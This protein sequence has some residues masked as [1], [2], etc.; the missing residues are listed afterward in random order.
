M[1]RNPD[2]WEGWYW[3]GEHIWGFD[4]A[5]GVMDQ[6]D[7]LEDTMQNTKLLIHWSE[8]SLTENFMHG[9]DNVQWTHWL[10]ELG[11]ERIFVTPDLNQAAGKYADKWI[12]VRPGTDPALAAAIANVWITEG[13]YQKDY[14]N[15]HGYGFDKWNAYVMGAEDGVPKTPEWAESITGVKA[16]EIR[17]L[18]RKWASTTTSLCILFGGACRGPYSTEW[19]RMMVLLLTMQGLGKPGVSYYQTVWS[20]PRDPTFVPIIGSFAAYADTNPPNPVMQSLYQT[21]LPGGIL[22]PPVT[23]Y[24]SGFGSS[25]NEQFV[26][27]TYP[28]K[29]YSEAKMI[30]MDNVARIT[31]WNCGNK[32]IEAYKSPKIQFTVAVH[33]WLENDMLFA[34]LILPESTWLEQDDIATI[35]SWSLGKGS[36]FGNVASVYM[37]KCIQ[38]L[39]ES[40]NP[41]DIYVAIASRLGIEKQYTEG[42]TVEDWIKTIFNKSTLPKFITY[43]DFKEKGY[44]VYKFPDNWPRN[45]GLQWFYNKPNIATPSDGVVTPSGKVEFYSQVLAKNFPDDKERPP[46]PHYIAEGPTHQESLTSAHAKTY[47]LL[48]E[49]AH[50][51]YRFHSR[52]NNISWLNEIPAY[53]VWNK[54]VCYEAV[55]INPKDASARGIKEGDVVRVFNERGGTL[56]A[57]HVTERVMPTVI[58]FSYGGTYRPAEPGKNYQDTAG[59]SNLISPYE[60]IS[61]NVSGMA[62]NG[63]LA[64]VEKWVGS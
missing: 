50:P 1:V 29:G 7:V 21:V 47:P 31:N 11:V 10:K 45:P 17:A 53:K 48:V 2:S 19:P 36:K 32:W 41:Y 25:H 22:N 39:G 23:W 38:P 43:D 58:R 54:G 60:T 9:C 14:V 44:Y 3:G 34:D 12:P 20:G 27:K 57:A 56:G 13:T 61:A 42:R 18:A 24:G 8:D 33:P 37:K 28:L 63:Y 64:Q 30:W 5:S 49:P 40:R 16:R 26:Q 55:W 6:L 35:G 51:R 15:T 59:L 62:V 52:E 46:V 4:W